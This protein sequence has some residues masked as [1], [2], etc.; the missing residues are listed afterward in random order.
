MIRVNICVY[1]STT[2]SFK[3]N[4]D[5]AR[6]DPGGMKH[7]HKWFSL[8]GNESR[9]CKIGRTNV[10]TLLIIQNITLS[11]TQ[12]FI[13][14]YFVRPKIQNC[15]HS[16]AYSYNKKNIIHNYIQWYSRTFYNWITNRFLYK[17]IFILCTNKWLGVPLILKITKFFFTD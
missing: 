12:V 6:Q 10:E 4:L 5:N 16:R 1:I 2:I 17:Y 8:K 13:N 3:I 15:V 9:S 11:K 14:K 7:W